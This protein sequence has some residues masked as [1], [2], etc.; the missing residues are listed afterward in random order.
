MEGR[1]RC[2]RGSRWLKSA[3]SAV[4]LRHRRSTGKRHRWTRKRD[5]PDCRRGSC[6]TDSSHPPTTSK[7]GRLEILQQLEF[8]RK[9]SMILF[10]EQYHVIKWQPMAILHFLRQKFADWLLF[11]ATA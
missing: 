7:R 8:R 6:S 9:L 3:A 10:L 5:R 11:D 1:P 4:R 2:V